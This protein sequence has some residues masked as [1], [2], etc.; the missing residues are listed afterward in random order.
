MLLI[1]YLIGKTVEYESNY[2][3]GNN[4]PRGEITVDG[5]YLSH[6]VAAWLAGGSL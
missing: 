3:G 4:I 6:F 2:G 1:S 5:G